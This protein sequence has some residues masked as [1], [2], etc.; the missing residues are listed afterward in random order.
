M[1]DTQPATEAPPAPS[2][3]LQ[4][5]RGHPETTE[6]LR[7]I[8]TLKERFNELEG[9]VAALEEELV[10]NKGNFKSSDCALT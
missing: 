7:N 8:D 2:G 9:R 5:I 10:T 3:S 4:Q 1:T 6:A